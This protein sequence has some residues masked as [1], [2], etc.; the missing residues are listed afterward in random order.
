MERLPGELEFGHF[1]L[2]KH[3]NYTILFRMESFGRHDENSGTF[4]DG[5][6]KTDDLT[7]ISGSIS[8]KVAVS[9]P[10]GPQKI[11]SWPIRVGVFRNL[12]VA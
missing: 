9:R 10:S 2:S 6:L 4:D 5:G 3:D 8:Q 1:D 7:H 11:F 12:A